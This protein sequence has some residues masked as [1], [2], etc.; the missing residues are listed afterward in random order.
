M[1]DKFVD[2]TPAQKDPYKAKASEFPVAKAPGGKGGSTSPELG[3][4]RALESSS[5]DGPSDWG[6]GG[7]A[8]SVGVNDEGGVAVKL[9]CSLDLKDGR[10]GCK[11]HTCTKAGEVC[12]PNVHI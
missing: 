6:K 10:I 4:P 1:H 5:A 11:N 8:F 12:D 7:K 2:Q 9:D 3:S